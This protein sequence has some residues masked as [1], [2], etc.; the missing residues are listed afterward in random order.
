MKVKITY[1][2]CCDFGTI[3]DCFPKLCFICPRLHDYE[4]SIVK[5]IEPEELINI[6]NCERNFKLKVL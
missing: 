5:E 1:F 2:D 3:V 4:F 6:L